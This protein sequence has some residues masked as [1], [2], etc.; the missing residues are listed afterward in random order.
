VFTRA[1]YYTASSV[2]WI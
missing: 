2:S 1:S